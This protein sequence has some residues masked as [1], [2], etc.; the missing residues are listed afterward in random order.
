M[1]TIVVAEDDRAI[2]VALTNLLELEGYDVIAFADGQAASDWLHTVEPKLLEVN[3]T[4]AGAASASAVASGNP[5]DLLIFDVMMPYLD[6]LT[7]CRR[8]RAKGVLTPI[9][10]VTARTETLD[11][12]SGLDAGADAYIAKPFEPDELLANVRSLLRRIAMHT[13][14]TPVLTVSD[15]RIDEAAR[16]AWRGSRELELT[17]TEFDLL[18]MLA[19]NVGMVVTHTSIYENVWQYDFGPDSKTL[20]VYISYL[21]RKL[22]L[23]D[24]SP[25]LHTVRGVGYSLRAT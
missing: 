12:V 7:L 3:A 1:A 15:L 21:R 24:E 20:Q 6:G 18:V 17:K 23:P 8:L 25:L 4:A 2:R 11:R 14:V 5:A 13:E 9:L 22:D 19:R 16:R 10:M